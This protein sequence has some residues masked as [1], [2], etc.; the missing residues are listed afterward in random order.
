MPDNTNKITPYF[1][2][3]NS[4]I[5]FEETILTNGTEI[6]FP[7]ETTR[8]LR[9]L[10]NVYGI[11]STLPGDDSGNE[12]KNEVKKLIIKLRA[13]KTAR[14]KISFTKNIITGESTHTLNHDPDP[15]LFST[16]K[17]NNK[18]LINNRILKPLGT[19]INLPNVYSEFRKL[20]L[21]EMISSDIDDSIILNEDLSV[22]EAYSG[23]IFFIEDEHVVTPSMQTGCYPGILR[24]IVINELKMMNLPV[25]EKDHIAIEEILD[26]KEIIT[27][28]S[29]GIFSIRGIDKQRYFD[30]YRNL[31]IARIVKN[32]LNC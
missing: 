19:T 9:T 3:D 17:I 6:I 30:D 25:V 18:C 7:Y 27:A 22:T 28:G 24:N 16:G 21:T 1:M 2:S 14:I 12:L 23:N 29:Y 4:I 31:L 32:Y 5:G 20:V 26:S 13:Y 11:N 8:R 15:Y 10:L